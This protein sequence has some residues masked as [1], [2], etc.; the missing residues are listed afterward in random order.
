MLPMWKC[1]QSQCCQFSIG[2]G[3][4]APPGR[5]LSQLAAARER[6]PPAAGNAGITAAVR[7]RCGPPRTSAA[8]P[9]RPSGAPFRTHLHE[10]LSERARSFQC[11]AF[12]TIHLPPLSPP[13]RTSSPT[14]FIARMARQTLFAENPSPFATLEM[15]A[16][17]VSANAY[18][19]FLAFSRKS[20]R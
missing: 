14:S 6:G 13:S 17:G 3:G 15:S 19:T 8:C 2:R 12:L 18:R 4:N 1:C 7:L 20:L 9:L 5:R 10:S 16:S 11:H